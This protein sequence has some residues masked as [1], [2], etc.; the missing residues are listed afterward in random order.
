MTDRKNKDKVLD[1]NGRKLLL[2]CQSANLIIANGRLH[3]DRNI[4]EFT[5]CGHNGLSTVDYLL[6]NPNDASSLSDFNILLFN[7]FSDH[8]PIHISFPLKL[9]TNNPEKPTC[10]NHDTCADRINF[11]ES[12]ASIFRN[13]LGNSHEYLE[14][15]TE[16]VNNGH[17][18]DIVQN[19]TTLIYETSKDVFGQK[20]YKTNDCSSKHNFT[21]NEWY[22]KDCA[23]AKKDFKKARNSF[24]KNV[25]D[26]NKQNFISTRTKYNRVKR[27][28]KHKYKLK[29]S[30]DICDLAKKKPKQFWKS[31]KKK[32]KQNQ[33][34]HPNDPVNINAFFEH[35]KEVYGGQ[36]MPQDE[37]SDVGS[38]SDPDLDLE[39]SDA[40]IQEAILSQKNNKSSGIDNLTAELF[41]TSCDLILPFLSKLF[42]RL[43]TNGE[44][45]SAWAEGA[46]VP[47]YKRKNPRDPNN[48]RGITLINILG[49][50]YSQILLNR[51]SKW[52]GKHDKLSHN[53]FGFQ[54][55]KST[56]DCIFI[57]SSIISKVLQAG[58]KLYCVFIDYEKA[59]DRIDR[60]LL[61]H[62]LIFE[63]VSSKF[64]KAVRSM[65]NVVRACIKHKSTLSGF[66]NTFMGLKQGEFSA[67]V[68]VVHK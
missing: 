48:Y 60:S 6:L 27:N 31:I 61:W 39:I 64:V 38:T 45:P 49:K 43:F 10:E 26:E 20:S 8:A 17:V 22:N 36:H 52:S 44:Y 1:K 9:S 7:E 35:F 30:K 34:Q 51:L 14:Q 68:H 15:L 54:K 28:A 42:N 40:E 18:D 59:F 62:K 63:K 50:I 24:L 12:R 33:P 13:K 55:G 4:G 5:Y 29:E 3:N 57:F 58:E 11:N 41:K 66:F 37:Q 23:Q 67:P 19:F 2:L 65:Y 16:Q 25:N 47:I 56:V 53:Q 46:I 32:Y 21:R